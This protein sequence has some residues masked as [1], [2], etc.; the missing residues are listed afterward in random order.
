MIDLSMTFEDME[1]KVKL[2]GLIVD[3]KISPLENPEKFVGFDGLDYLRQLDLGMED[4]RVISEVYLSKLLEPLDEGTGIFS[5]IRELN[6]NACIH[7]NKFD[8]SLPVYL[9]MGYGVVGFVA[10]F[11]DSGEGFDYGKIGRGFKNKGAGARKFNEDK[12]NV[13]SWEEKG[14]IANYMVKFSGR[15]IE[16]WQERVW[17]RNNKNSLSFM[18]L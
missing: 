17:M 3:E 7:G 15:D 12:S 2:I 18:D 4:A 9:K 11:I 14:N 5:Y 6:Y 13:V 8:K 1:E 10:R 16:L